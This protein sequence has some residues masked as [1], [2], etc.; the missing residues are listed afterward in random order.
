MIECLNQQGDPTGYKIPVRKYFGKIIHNLQFRTW[1]TFLYFHFSHS[2]TS[3]YISQVLI[4][5]PPC[6]ISVSAMPNN[7][8]LAV[9]R[10]PGR[11]SKTRTDG[12][13]LGVL[14]AL[15]FSKY[16]HFCGK[17]IQILFLPNHLGNPEG[18]EMCRAI[19]LGKYTCHWI[20]KDIH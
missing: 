16:W 2:R 3:L 7:H 20:K 14:P 8:L 5:Q 1:N 17:Q 18:L 19:E 13:P 4:C 10:F 11:L 6:W 9:K 15:C 12:I